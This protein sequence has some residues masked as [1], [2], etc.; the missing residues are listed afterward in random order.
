[1]KRIEIVSSALIPGDAGEMRV[2]H[3]GSILDLDDDVAGLLIAGSRAVL[4]PEGAK[5]R[6]TGKAIEAEADRKAAAQASPEA[7]M[8]ALIAAAVQAALASAPA[9][10][11]TPDSGAGA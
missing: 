4:A 5:V 3:V 8:A 7:A 11:A 2:A 10:A 9:K 6:D 1:M